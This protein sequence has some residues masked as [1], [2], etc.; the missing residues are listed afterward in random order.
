MDEI[1]SDIRS[2]DIVHSFTSLSKPRLAQL[3]PLTEIMA[4]R[5]WS[6]DD[7]A[8]L[9]SSTLGSGFDHVSELMA[10]IP[11]GGHVMQ[12][13]KGLVN[14]LADLGQ[15]DRCRKQQQ[16]ENQIEA[17]NEMSMLWIRCMLIHSSLSFADLLDKSSLG[18]VPVLVYDICRLSLLMNCQIWA[19]RGADHRLRTARALVQRLVPL[20]HKFTAP[21]SKG[22]PVSTVLSDFY[23]WILVLGLMLAYEEYDFAGEEA[24]LRQMAPFLAYCMIK[25][26]P[27]AWPTVS[28]ILSRFLWSWKGCDITGREAWEFGCLLLAEGGH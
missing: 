1:E 27:E 2:F 24:C 11:E 22:L 3:Q 7:A 28:T 8:R 25:A 15:L 14:L 6:T 18:G 12:V 23:I 13:L 26:R 16:T 5:T 19:C 10:S 17:P 21:G 20:L 4:L 9:L